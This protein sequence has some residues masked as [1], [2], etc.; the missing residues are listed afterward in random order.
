MHARKEEQEEGSDGVT[1]LS[2]LEL[3][4]RVNVTFP[5][6]SFILVAPPVCISLSC[7]VLR[8]GD[9]EAQGMGDL[10]HHL[11]LLLVLLVWHACTIRSAI[12]PCIDISASTQDGFEPGRLLHSV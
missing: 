3:L 2:Y 6:R 8:V 4:T 12:A 9:G 5:H 1:G 10:S 7:T 11:S